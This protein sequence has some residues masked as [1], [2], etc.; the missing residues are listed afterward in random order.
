MKPTYFDN[1]F[2]NKLKK[3][4]KF[5]NKKNYKKISI[6]MPSYNHAKF[7]ERSILSVL[8]QNYPNTELIIVDGGSKD[9]TD[10]IIKKYQEYISLWISEKDQ[11]QSDALNK[12]FKCCTGEIYGWLNSDDV[13]LP[14]AFKNAN[15]IL[16]KNPNKKI[17]FGDWI[18]INNQDHMIDY[19][20]AFDFN[21]NHFKYEGFHINTQ[22]MFWRRNVHN[23]F[24]GFQIDLFNTMDYQML[25]EFGINEGNQ[26]FI[27][28]PKAIGA[29]RRYKGQK[30]SGMNIS[31]LR[32]HMLISK[33][34]RYLDKYKIIGKLKRIYFRLRRAVW[35]YK[36]GGIINLINRIKKAYVIFK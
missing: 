4:K 33:R 25:I 19:Q 30:T 13:Y 20:H 2:L 16:K 36:R 11:G 31:V 7:I 28:T 14:N 24:S 3:V 27:R 29:F 6:V 5:K 34:Y 17:I 23:R 15:S 12:G 22:S 35:Y 10:K 26:S 8:N 32:E 18:S 1:D 21:L 9:G